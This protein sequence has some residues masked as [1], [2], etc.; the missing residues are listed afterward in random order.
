MTYIWII[1]A[2]ELQPAAGDKCHEGWPETAGSPAAE[3]LLC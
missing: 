3:L 1:W 2:K